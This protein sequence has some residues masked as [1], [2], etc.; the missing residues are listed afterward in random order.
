M[1][2]KQ[3]K[4]VL[5]LSYGPVPTP[6]F[7]K[8]EGGGMRCWGLAT[9]L[10]DNGHNVTVSVN[11]GFK[12]NIAKVDGISL[13]NW[14][15]N[16]SFKEY[17]NSFDA[18]IVSY[19]MGDLSV[20]IADNISQHVQLILD[21]YVPIFIEVSARD[22]EDKA[23][24]L[25]NYYQ[26]IK[27]FNHVLKRG[28]YFLCANEPQ[29][30]MYAGILGS[31]GVI[32][33]YSYRSE[34]L[35]V[36]PFGI[37]A[38]QNIKSSDSPYKEIGIKEKDFVLLWFGGLY[39]WFDFS[40]I[41]DAVTN[42]SKNKNFKF[43]L[44]GG[45]NPYN[46]NPDFIK[47][48]E[49]VHESFSK[50]GL[51]NKSVFFIDWV[52]FNQRLDWYKNANVVISLN[53]DGEENI[54]SWRTR[55]MD[56][57]W[58]NLPMLTNGGDPLSNQLLQEKAAIKIEKDPNVIVD[59]IT[60]LINNPKQLHELNANLKDVRDTYFWPKI[61][62][63]LSDKI[64]SGNLFYLDQLIFNENAGIATKNIGSGTDGKLRHVKKIRK[65]TR[66]V[67]QKG[68][69]RSAKFAI[70]I[71]NSQIK[72]KTNAIVR[73]KAPKVVLL[74]H[75]IDETGAP[76]VL[77]DIA[78]DFSAKYGAKNIH[79][80][81]PGIKK[82]MLNDLLNCG[83]KIHKMAMGI[84]GRI[85]QA[86]LNIKPDDFVLMNT[87]ALYENYRT[88][89]YW[90]LESGK[91]NNA[92]WFIHEDKPEIRL[93]NKAEVIRIKRLI[94][95]GKLRVVVPSSQT[96]QEYNLFF[97]TDKVKSVSLR[98]VVP[99]QFEKPLEEQDF[100]TIRFVISG[101]PS[102]GRKGQLFFLSAL[103]LFESKYKKP[104]KKYKDY[105]VD[106]IAIE[107]DYISQQIKAIGSAI[108]GNK[109]HIHPK[110]SRDE[111]LK[112]TSECNVT[113]CVSLNETF[114][115]FVAEGMLMGHVILRNYSSGWQE[116]MQ[117][118]ENG[119][120]INNL[121]LTDT[122][123]KIEIIL[124]KDNKELLDLSAK[125]KEIAKKFSY[126]SYLNEIE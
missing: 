19:C 87:V 76:L 70:D 31:L 126:I 111:A 63:V 123:K 59:V 12:Q 56:Y 51:L 40:P 95:D 20:F 16:D 26:D 82:Y 45:K 91:L 53:Q 14:Q 18:V 39:P 32:N 15:L 7:Q 35:L 97:E 71:V 83:Y 3:A 65:L 101:T 27:R 38:E 125:S 116:Q 11:E 48:Y 98:V 86:N 81:A 46:S 124:S 120:L 109:L 108:L 57:V 113:V 122:A 117:D 90:L 72:S 58:G 33:P 118:S 80:V 52:D 10:R 23:T 5:I 99:K 30:H 106:F 28:D 37:D 60:K 77:I 89:V 110:V 68:I 8:I 69:K 42:L 64:S 66:K 79:I 102:D 105:T 112:I 29:K 9:G 43:V 21:C 121:D 1:Q 88:Y 54:Y 17:I 104:D 62:K 34:R 41:I 78:K 103:Q 93:T 92:V 50:I 75:P 49:S 96:A 61:T 13:H 67:R 119:Y 2:L 22:S 74:S 100:N 36:V 24:E 107:D 73:N 6:E 85:I 4:N 115:L 55:V 94:S 84:G 47:Q 114:A 44:V 25:T